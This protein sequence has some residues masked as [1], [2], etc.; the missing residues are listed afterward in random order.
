MI[1]LDFVSRQRKLSKVQ[2]S[3]SISLARESSANE[4][5][6]DCPFRNI[7]CSATHFKVTS[8]KHL[9]LRIYKYI[10]IIYD[11]ANLNIPQ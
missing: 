4:K 9:L 1:I 10:Y 5:F 11:K 3:K 8:D 2:R 6:M 7:A